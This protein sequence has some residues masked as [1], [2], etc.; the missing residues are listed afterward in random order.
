[1]LSPELVDEPIRRNNST[2]MKNENRKQ[3]PLFLAAERDWPGR[4]FDLE[5]AKYPEVKRHKRH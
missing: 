2:G 1:M 4:A 3:R 5:R